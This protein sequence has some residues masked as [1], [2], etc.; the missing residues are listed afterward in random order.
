MGELVRR[1]V[2]AVVRLDDGTTK[3]GILIV[4]RESR[5]S[6][7]LNNQKKDFVVLVDKEGAGCMLN[8]AHIVSVLETKDNT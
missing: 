2:H 3:E 7:F 1:K 6:D 8:K 5:L 4:P